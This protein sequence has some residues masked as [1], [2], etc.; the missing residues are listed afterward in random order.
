MSKVI[1]DKVYL[2]YEILSSRQ[3]GGLK[4]YVNAAENISFKLNIGDKLGVIGRN[5]SGKSTLLSMIAGTISQNSGDIIIEGERLALINQSIGLE[6]RATLRENAIIRGYAYSLTGE[7]LDS[8]VESVL[9]L[10]GLSG[11]ADSALNTLST[12]MLGRFN[13]A[14]NTQVVKPITIL[15]EWIG[16]LNISGNEGSAML[17]KLSNEADIVVIASHNDALV[18]K[19]CNRALLIEQGVVIYDGEN[20]EEALGI[21]SEI[22]EIDPSNSMS[23]SN[24][25]IER[26]RVRGLKAVESLESKKEKH[27]LKEKDEK[28]NKLIAKKDLHFLNMGRVKVTA[29]IRSL[30]QKDK[31]E[32]NL[33]VHPITVKLKNIPAG[34]KVCIIYCDPF[35]RFINAFY[36]RKSQGGLGID[37]PWSFQEKTA[38]ENF[39]TPSQLLIGLVSDNQKTQFSALTALAS[40]EHLL[41]SYS[42]YLDSS[43]ALLDRK[44]DLLFVESSDNLESLTA[45]FEKCFKTKINYSELIKERLWFDKRVGQVGD[46]E[47]NIFNNL[48]ESDINLFKALEKGLN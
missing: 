11:R 38:F 21:L 37:A 13:I 30:S 23:V 44:K 46:L 34:E 33:I 24:I 48:F 26:E 40:I 12:G 45:K 36:S 20:V 14:L 3:K 43:N 7:A 39:N 15:D 27:K 4:S 28:S 2:R 17:N 1:F 47:E 9:T 8:F 19:I 41:R 35:T 29:L 18:K 31:L 10:S 5:G 16:T 22:T 6:S 32:Y 25:K 42:W